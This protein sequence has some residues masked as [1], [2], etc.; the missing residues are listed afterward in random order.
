MDLPTD[1]GPDDAAEAASGAAPPEQRSSRPKLRPPAGW[2]DR[3]SAGVIYGVIATGVLLAAESSKGESYAKT[4]AAIS[5]TLL[6][7][8]IAHGYARVVAQRLETS[9]SWA[10]G[11][12]ARALGHELAILRGAVLPLLAVIVAWACG[13]RLRTGIAAGIWTASAA[14]VFFEVVAGIRARLKSGELVLQAS[15][16]AL[17]GAAILAVRLVLH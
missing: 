3:N 6:L 17:V 12:V 9:G 13:A 4:V 14:L 7:Y 1:G 5:V 8:W 2:I 16:G 10:V 15:V 11:D